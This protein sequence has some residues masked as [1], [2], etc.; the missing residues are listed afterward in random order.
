M[1]GYLFEDVLLS[2]QLLPLAVGLGDHD[3]QHILPIVGDIT[4]KKHQVLQQLDN[5][6]SQRDTRREEC[7]GLTLGTLRT[8]SR[9][10][11]GNHPFPTASPAVIAHSL[12]PDFHFSPSL[13]L[14]CPPRTPLPP[15][16]L[17]SKVPSRQR[18]PGYSDLEKNQ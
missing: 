14:S 12:T 15:S 10:P 2:H 3:V 6:P 11:R 4:D 9:A 18:I 13:T 8:P 17:D 16:T 7:E 1:H 5:K